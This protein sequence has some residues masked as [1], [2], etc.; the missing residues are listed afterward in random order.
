[1]SELTKKELIA[2][3]EEH[4]LDTEGTKATLASR[5]DEHL[6][7]HEPHEE[8]VDDTV[9]EEEVVEVVEVDLPK[10]SIR[11]QIKMAWK[12]THGGGHP[13]PD[14]WERLT[15]EVAC[16]GMTIAEVKALFESQA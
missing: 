4:E 10:S 12:Q 15:H 11:Q 16:G 6:T 7:D 9:V 1:M 13:D 2:L 5:L 8:V 3:C 14:Q